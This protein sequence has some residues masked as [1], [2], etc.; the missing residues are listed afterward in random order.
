M[1]GQV[2]SLGTENDIYGR[3][4]IILNDLLY[5]EQAANSLPRFG[6]IGEAEIEILNEYQE[7]TI[8]HFA[9]SESGWVFLPFNSNYGDT[10]SLE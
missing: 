2:M 10:S 5:V 4:S 7:Y 3:S 8:G 1:K 9:H 6:G